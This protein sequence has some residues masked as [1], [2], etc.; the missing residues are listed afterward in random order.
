M[1]NIIQFARSCPENWTSKITSDKLNIGLWCWSYVA[2]LLAAGTV[3]APPLQDGEH[4]AR[5]QHF[6]NV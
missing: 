3:Q 4:E 5:L 1:P 6:L 2:E